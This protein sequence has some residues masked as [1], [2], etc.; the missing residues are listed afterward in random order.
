MSITTI[1]VNYNAGELLQQ[2]GFVIGPGVAYG[3][4][5]KEYFRLSLTT[6]E[7]D[8]KEGMVRL[9]RFLGK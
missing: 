1:I 5:G 4:H 7:E 3:P 9:K 2:E 8:I 6:P